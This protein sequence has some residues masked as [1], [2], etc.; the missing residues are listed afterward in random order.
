MTRVDRIKEVR[1]NH[2]H[3][4]QSI[5]SISRKVKLSRPTVQK[6][7]RT[8]LTEFTYKPRDNQAH[9]ATDKVKTIMES[10]VLEDRSKKKKHQRTAWRVYDILKEEHGFSGSYESKAR[11]KN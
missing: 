11:C 1:L 3:E 7:L 6:I 5:R 4:G 10:W 8:G 9:P 2:F